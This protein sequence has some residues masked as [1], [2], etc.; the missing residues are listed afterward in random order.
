M[1][2]AEIWKILEFLS[3]TFQFLVLKFSIYLN[4]HAFIMQ[5]TVMV[6]IRMHEQAGGS[7]PSLSIFTRRHLLSWFMFLVCLFFLFLC[8]FFFFFHKSQCLP[9]DC[10]YL[11]SLKIPLWEKRCVYPE[12]AALIKGI[13]VNWFCYY[14]PLTV[15]SSMLYFLQ[16]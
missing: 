4:R 5:L 1:F 2:W 8:F 16:I 12:L 10:A 13:M 14:S 15:D 11:K 7:G 9:R 6:Q 3:E